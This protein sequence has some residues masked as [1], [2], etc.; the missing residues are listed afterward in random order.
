VSRAGAGHLRWAPVGVPT[1]SDEQLLAMDEGELLE[2]VL[3]AS[4]SQVRHM[5]HLKLNVIVKSIAMAELDRRET[6]G[7]NR[8]LVWLAALTSAAAI[9]AIWLALGIALHWGPF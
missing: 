8:R 3:D 4:S 5:L 1:Y 6:R 9:A 2:Y 7:V